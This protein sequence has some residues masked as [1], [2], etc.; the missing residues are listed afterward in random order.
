MKIRYSYIIPTLAIITLLS[1]FTAETNFPAPVKEPA[2]AI[3]MNVSSSG[4]FDENSQK[5]CE[6]IANNVVYI[7]KLRNNQNFSYEE[8]DHYKDVSLSILK[9][10]IINGFLKIYEIYFY[11]KDTEEYALIA[12]GEFDIFA[13]SEKSKAEMI[14]DKN[15]KLVKIITKINLN[16]NADNN[17]K[18]IL[19]ANNDY[20]IICPENKI[21][22]IENNLENNT[23]VL[24]NRFKTFEQMIQHNPAIS[25]EIDLDQL[26]K[27]ITNINIPKPLTATKLIRLFIAPEQ[28]KFQI[29]IPEEKDRLE[30]KSELEKQTSTLNS[31]FD[32]KT[33]YK[34]AD[35]KTS[36][37]IQTDSNEEQ[38]QSISR[39]AMAFML[40]FFV[41]NKSSDQH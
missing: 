19:Q 2:A 28:N 20:L 25:A 4:I 37:F 14:F 10:S 22:E 6:E 32:N 12:K 21:A 17:Q 33:D 13:I 3:Y 34:L 18:M 29:S 31:V 16:N 24:G 1:G 30:I 9:D 23:N 27:D 39:K 38:V 11:Y 15:E 35:G 5:A 36:I 7:C 40:H 8:L 26:L 41:K